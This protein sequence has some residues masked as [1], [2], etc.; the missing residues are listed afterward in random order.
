M[1]WEKTVDCT[2]CTGVGVGITAGGLLGV[3]AGTNCFFGSGGFLGVIGTHSLSME[4]KLI[5]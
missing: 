4:W 2:G 5:N 3:E 1:G